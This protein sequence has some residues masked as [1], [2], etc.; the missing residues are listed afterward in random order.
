M[1]EMAGG[2]GGCDDDDYDYDDYYGD[3]GE[4][5]LFLSLKWIYIHAHKQQKFF[6][7]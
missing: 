2:D 4:Q 5:M 6:H 3:G 7:P 1:M